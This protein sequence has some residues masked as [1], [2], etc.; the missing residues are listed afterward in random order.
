MLAGQPEEQ[1]EPMETALRD[2]IEKV[3]LEQRG[4]P[5][6]DDL[7]QRVEEADEKY[8]AGLRAMLGLDQVVAINVGAAPDAGRGPRVLPRHRPAARRSCGG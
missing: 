5:V 1:R 8:F 7:R 2:A 6:P 3:R 4:E